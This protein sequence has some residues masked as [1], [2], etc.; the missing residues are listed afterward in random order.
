MPLVFTLLMLPVLNTTM[1]G[2]IAYTT[3]VRGAAYVLVEMRSE[4][5]LPFKRS[6]AERTFVFPQIL[7]DVLLVFNAVNGTSERTPT[8][9]TRLHACSSLQ[10]R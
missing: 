4:L 2:H 1:E 7:V 9:P 6:F 3:R 5:L 8:I 10:R